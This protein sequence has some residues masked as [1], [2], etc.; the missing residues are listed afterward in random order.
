MTS[1]SYTSENQCPPSAVTVLC[2]SQSNSRAQSQLRLRKKSVVLQLLSLHTNL[3]IVFGNSNTGWPWKRPLSSLSVQVWGHVHRK[4]AKLQILAPF[5]LPGS[6][7]GLWLEAHRVKMKHFWVEGLSQ[8]LPKV[9]KL[10]KITVRFIVSIWKPSV[11]GGIMVYSSHWIVCFSGYLHTLICASAWKYMIR[12]LTNQSMP[13]KQP[14]VIVHN[15]KLCLAV[16]VRTAPG[17][18]THTCLQPWKHFKKTLLVHLCNF[19]KL[20]WLNRRELYGNCRALKSHVGLETHCGPL[21]T[22]QND[23]KET[24]LTKAANAFEWR[25][26]VICL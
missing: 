19:T 10:L 22:V 25:L 24:H 4:A 6:S 3:L 20:S 13:W 23:I 16:R 11:T 12:I 15:G 2:C 5:F 7:W 26:C 1:W 9:H 8:A 17:C 21:R 18:L 14:P